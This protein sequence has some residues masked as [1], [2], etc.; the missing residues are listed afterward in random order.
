MGQ[1]PCTT[2]SN[3][4]SNLLQTSFIPDLHSQSSVEYWSQFT[5]SGSAVQT[6]QKLLFLRGFMNYFNTRGKKGGRGTWHTPSAVNFLTWRIMS[7]NR[8]LTHWRLLSHIVSFNTVL[9]S[10]KRNFHTIRCSCK[11]TLNIFEGLKKSN[12]QHI[13]ESGY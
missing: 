6:P 4:F 11:P 12:L 2:S 13:A 1:T 10:R 9:V 7:A 8:S 3:L 5:P